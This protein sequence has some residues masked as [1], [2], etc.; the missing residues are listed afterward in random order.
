MEVWHI[1]KEIILKDMKIPLP[2]DQIEKISTKVGQV[3][4]GGIR[5][6]P[7][8]VEVS[9][10]VPQIKSHSFRVKDGKIVI[11]DLKDKTVAALVECRPPDETS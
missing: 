1:I 7:I 6:S 11:V 4:P 9:A 3:V 8:P 10:K 5:L 2:Q